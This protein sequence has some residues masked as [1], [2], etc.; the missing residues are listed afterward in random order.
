MREARQAAQ[1]GRRRGVVDRIESSSANATRAAR[2]AGASLASRAGLRERRKRREREETRRLRLAVVALAVLAAVGF[3]G[4]F[5]VNLF[6]GAEEAPAV[7]ARTQ[8]VVLFQVTAADGV[9]VGNALLVHDG[10]NGGDAVVLVPSGLTVA[11]SGAE[12]E[13]LGE[14]AKAA[15]G[16]R[17]RE[18]L[19]KLLGVTIDGSFQ[20]DQPAFA[21]LID[22]SN[23]RVTIDVPKKV[24]TSG[25][26]ISAGRQSLDGPTAAAYAT[27]LRPGESEEARLDRL[28]AVLA[29]LVPTLPRTPGAAAA[30]PSALAGGVRLS[31][32]DDQL[33]AVLSGLAKAGDVRYERLPAKAA[34]GDR[35]GY[36]FDRRASGALLDDLLGASRT[37]G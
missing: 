24:T 34:G 6:R 17:A 19:S 13:S 22:Q 16:K 31:L 30:L 33:G 29:A 15:G 20:V 14:A 3:A 10:R 9:A 36:A 12:P 2:S 18:Q 26:A 1:R 4:W 28:E 37:S 21:E 23:G 5:A 8:R 25:F 7:V 11:G 32:P 35:S 27:Y